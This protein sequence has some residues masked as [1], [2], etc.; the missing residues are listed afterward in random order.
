MGE[1]GTIFRKNRSKYKIIGTVNLQ[2]ESQSRKIYYP[3]LIFKV[4][5][6]GT[7]GQVLNINSTHQFQRVS[8]LTYYQNRKEQ[9]NENKIKENKLIK[10]KEEKIFKKLERRPTRETQRENETLETRIE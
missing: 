3:I 1:I 4:N 8:S 6:I 9:K 7:Y 10:L 2:K 5:K